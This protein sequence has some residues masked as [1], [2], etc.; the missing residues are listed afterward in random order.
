MSFRLRRSMKEEGVGEIGSGIIGTDH[1][2]GWR[3]MQSGRRDHH[4]G[5]HSNARSSIEIFLRLWLQLN[6]SVQPRCLAR[7]V[8]LMP[9]TNSRGMQ[10]SALTD[11]PKCSCFSSFTFIYNWRRGCST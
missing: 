4:V 11:N 10:A 9:P 1:A 5:V 8:L 6:R 7:V 3:H 2:T